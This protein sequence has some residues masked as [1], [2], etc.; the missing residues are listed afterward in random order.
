MRSL[1]ILG[2]LAVSGCAVETVT[3]APF[4]D[5]IGGGGGINPAALQAFKNGYYAFSQ[6][7]GCVTCHA[8]VVSPM[9]SSSNLTAAYTAAKS[10][11]DF[12]SVGSSVLISYVG[13][14]HCSDSACSNPALAGTVQGY[15]ESWAAAE[16]SAPSGGGGG[17]GVGVVTPAVPPKHLTAAVALPA[18][19]PSI[20]QAAV[21]VRFLLNAMAP[22]FPALNNAVAELEVQR[23]GPGQY[24][25]TRFK[26]AGASAP[27]RITGVHVYVRAAAATGIG[28]EDVYQGNLW[29]NDV[30][31]VAVIARP[32]PLPATPMNVAVLETLALI[33]PAQSSA[34]V[35]TIGFENIENP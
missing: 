19:I 35:L 21:P 1:L 26:I 8:S 10:K 13:N 5:N 9:F 29:K 33:M 30:L 32:N 28:V 17:G 20:N 34:D 2:F 15:L 4:G 23:L 11:V 25:V 27:V 14:A 22:A 7:Q 12:A 6:S 18:T 16:A 3:T 31:N 24:R